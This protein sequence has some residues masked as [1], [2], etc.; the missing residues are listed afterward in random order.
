M[1]RT[2]MIACLLLVTCSLVPM[3]P[4]SGQEKP[5]SKLFHATS[6]HHNPPDLSVVT[7]SQWQAIDNAVDRALVYLASQQAPDGSLP[8]MEA[9]KPA[10]TALYAMAAISAGH[11]P[12]EGP[13]GESINRAIDFILDSQN[14]EGLF[15]LERLSFLTDSTSKPGQ[16]AV[17]NHGICGTLL[18]EVYGMTDSDR[19]KRIKVAI[20][21]ALAFLRMMQ[22]H[23]KKSPLD[24]GGFRYIKQIKPGHSDSDLSVT[25]WQNHVHAFGTQRWLRCTRRLCERDD[26]VRSSLLRGPQPAS[27]A[28][29]CSNKRIPLEA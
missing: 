25:S 4:A 12:G 19:A 14:E 28:T 20:E 1:L 16:I 26:R 22:T 8:S 17:Y 27:F 7:P 23:P 18:G 9:A 3:Q 2:L 11:E 5:V 6:A 29:P 10:V 21:K 15:S 13:Y 24:K